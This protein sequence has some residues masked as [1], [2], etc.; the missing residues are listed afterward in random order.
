MHTLS[1]THTHTNIHIHIHIHIHTLTYTRTLLLIHAYTYTYRRAINYPPR[2]IGEATQEAFFKIHDTFG[3]TSSD[4]AWTAPVLDLLFLVGSVAE[5]KA[6]TEEPVILRLRV[7]LQDEPEETGED[8][9]EESDGDSFT[10]RLLNDE[11]WESSPKNGQTREA[12]EILSSLSTRQL[13]TLS[14]ASKYE[15][16]CAVTCMV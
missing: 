2:G 12:K 5:R 7:R 6:V 16:V 15:R 8:D 4:F 11:E 13:K 10:I 1:H 9:L 14:G 3:D